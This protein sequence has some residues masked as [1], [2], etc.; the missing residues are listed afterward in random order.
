MSDRLSAEQL[1][2][3]QRKLRSGEKIAAVKLYLD[4]TG[5]SLLDAKRFVE[6]LP[7]HPESNS[8]TEADSASVWNDERMDEILDAIHAGKKLEAVKLYRA[9]T[10]SS[11]ADSKEAVEKLM[12]QFEPAPA[13][14][15][16][17]EKGCLAMTWMLI[18]LIGG[19][20]FVFA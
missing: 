19:S 3:I 4:A 5:C 8:A 17:Q 9:A 6:S 13:N 1:E 14:H 10:G 2:A 7:V 11:L 18:V 12:Q 20:L 15:L 16:V